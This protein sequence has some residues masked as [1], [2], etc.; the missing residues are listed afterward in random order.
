VVGLREALLRLLSRGAKPEADPDELVEVAFVKVYEG[1]RLAAALR[2]AGVAATSVEAM[3][4]ATEV[5]SD[6]RVMVARRDAEQARR[7]L[8]GLGRA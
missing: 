3:N 1:E 7:I 5:R 6:A 2:S 4:P 8:E